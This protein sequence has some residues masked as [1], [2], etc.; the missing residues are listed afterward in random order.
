MSEREL[1]QFQ[2]SRHAGRQLGI[3]GKSGAAASWGARGWVGL[4]HK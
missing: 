2:V 3:H 1:V 4:G